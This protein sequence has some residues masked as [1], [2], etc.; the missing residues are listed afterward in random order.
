MAFQG[1]LATLSGD[2]TTQ[3]YSSPVTIAWDG[4]DIYDT[5][6]AHDPVTNNS[7]ITIPSAWNNLYG[8]FTFTA[9][10]ALI[11][12]ASPL[13]GDILKAAANYPGNG[14]GVVL[15]GNGNGQATTSAWL[16]CLTGPQLLATADIWTTRLLAA[17]DTS[18]TLKAESSFGVIVHE[19]PSELM[20]CLAKKASD[21]TTA[22]YTTPAVVAWDGGDEYDTHAI[23]D[24]S[25]NNTKLIIPAALNGKYVV[26][27]GTV[28]ATDTGGNRPHSVA[29]RKG[30]SLTYAGFGGHSNNSQAGGTGNGE[31]RIGAWTQAIQVATN[32]EFELLF[33]SS[34]D[35]SI[36]VKADKS[37]F[38]LR[39][40]G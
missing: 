2:K 34:V 3:N 40:V 27:G 14:V 20:Q 24:P 19:N 1:C 23:H 9:S 35:S 18:V 5:N 26:V 39:V 21:Q 10:I 13:Q 7:R 36:T 33:W 28:C 15:N 11:N 31:G 17:T 16:Q 29:V 6:S 22:D 32:D 25:S 38:G 8:I 30:G 12:T 37:S 4:T